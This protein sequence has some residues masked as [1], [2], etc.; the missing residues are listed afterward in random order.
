MKVDRKEEKEKE[1]GKVLGKEWK[2]ETHV[3]NRKT[4]NAR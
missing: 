4:G 2:Q 3:G 1:T